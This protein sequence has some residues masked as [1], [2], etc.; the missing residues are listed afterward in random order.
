VGR[1]TDGVGFYGVD[2]G[3][4]IKGD[5]YPGQYKYSMLPLKP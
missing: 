2:A 5:Y 3:K 1:P 4:I